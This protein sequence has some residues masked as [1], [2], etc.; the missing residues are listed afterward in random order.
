MVKRKPNS[1]TLGKSHFVDGIALL[2]KHG[3]S[4]RW[5]NGI[6][7]GRKRKQCLHIKKQSRKHI[8]K[9]N[10]IIKKS[11]QDRRIT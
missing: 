4:L 11:T 5:R 3:I 10:A 6:E 7:V 8:E 9:R 2:S 1:V